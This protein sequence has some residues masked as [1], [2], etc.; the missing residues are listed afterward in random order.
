MALNEI[1]QKHEA[2][3]QEIIAKYGNCLPFVNRPEM[4]EL[5]EL[6]HQITSIMFNGA[7]TLVITQQQI[8]E[9]SE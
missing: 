2:K 6:A 9:W 3:R 7:K 1:I 8:Q 5:D 4:A